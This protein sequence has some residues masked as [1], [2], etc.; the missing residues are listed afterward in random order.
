MARGKKDMSRQAAKLR[1][2]AAEL[3]EKCKKDPKVR[4]SEC[5]PEQIREC[6]GAEGDHPCE[7][8]KDT[9]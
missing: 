2:R 4:P 3:E 8:D 5:S 7:S 9:S 1:A 6:H